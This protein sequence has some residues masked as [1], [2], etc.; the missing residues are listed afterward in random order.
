[1]IYSKQEIQNI[2]DNAVCCIGDISNSI[3]KKMALGKSYSKDRLKFKKVFMYLVA[4]SSWTQNNDGTIP[5]GADNQITEDQKNAILSKLQQ[6]C[7]CG[8]QEIST[9][10]ASGSSRYVVN[11]YLTDGYLIVK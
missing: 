2:K 1:M 5:S 6:L 3:S 9:G 4:I 8:C 11:G 7:S 10:S